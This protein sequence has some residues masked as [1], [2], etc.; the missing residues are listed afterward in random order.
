LIMKQE[1]QL[2][3]L[4]KEKGMRCQNLL[5]IQGNVLRKKGGKMAPPY[6]KERGRGLARRSRFP[7]GGKS[8]CPARGKGPVNASS[9]KKGKKFTHRR[10]GFHQAKR[11]KRRVQVRSRRSVTAR[12]LPDFP[13]RKGRSKISSLWLG[14][15]RPSRPQRGGKAGQ[16][17]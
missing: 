16:F 8:A 17:S 10:Q 13:R 11:G 1:T 3:S 7:W 4:R 12:F 5:T 2:L 15:D 6:H 14:G 9:I